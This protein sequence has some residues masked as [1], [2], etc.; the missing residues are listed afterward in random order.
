M[1]IKYLYR[2]NTGELKEEKDKTIEQALNENKGKEIAFIVQIEEIPELLKGLRQ[3]NNL[4]QAQ[5]GEKLGKG[6]TKQ[7]IYQIE[8]GR[9]SIGF[10]LLRKF[11]EIFNI[12]FALSVSSEEN[13]SFDL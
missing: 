8:T 12:K 9:R 11:E 4:T 10:G 6:Y 2:S 1:Q 13:S 5:I 7:A 3:A